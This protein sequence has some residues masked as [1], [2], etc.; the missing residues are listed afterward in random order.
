M[1]LL[2]C[3]SLIFCIYDSELRKING[4]N[5]KHVAVYGD[6]EADGIDTDGNVKFRCWPGGT[7]YTNRGSR[8]RA[9]GAAGERGSIGIG[10][11]CDC[12]S[13]K[14]GQERHRP[15]IQL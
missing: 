1:I 12:N 5:V 9:A 11:E 2:F 8:M 6:K 3:C 4:V 10:G 13:P 14:R 15:M 7:I